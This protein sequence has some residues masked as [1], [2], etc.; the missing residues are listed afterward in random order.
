MMKNQDNYLMFVYRLWYEYLNC[1]KKN[2]LLF[3]YGNLYY[4][5]AFREFLS[6]SVV[7]FGVIKYA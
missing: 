6:T 3:L 4:R 2:V 5:Y 1:A 7:L